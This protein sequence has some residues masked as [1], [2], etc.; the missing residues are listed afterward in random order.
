MPVKFRDYYEILGV[1]RDAS[2]EEIQKAYRKLARKYHPDVNTDKGAEDKF[3]EINEA[4]EV[5]KDPDKRKKYDA[6]GANWQSG[7]DFSPPPGWENMHF[8]YGPGGQ[9]MGDFNFSRFGHTGFSDFFDMLFGDSFEGLGSQGRRSAFSSQQDFGRGGRDH[10]VEL[11][12]TLEE[13]YHGGKKKFTLQS[14]ESD[15][16][17]RVRQKSKNY[18]VTIPAGITDG[19][20]I[21]LGGQGGKGAGGGKSGDLYIKLKILPHPVFR[22]KEYDIEV[23]VPVTPWEAALGGKIKVPTLDKTATMTLPPGT[24][25]GQKMRLK[26]KGLRKKGETRG[27]LY[28]VIKMAI[29]KKLTAKEKELF[30]KLAEVSSFNPRK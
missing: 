13:A 6:L 15:Q 7:Q 1:S 12:I 22:L 14:S 28:A 10:E 25:G 18:D 3:K 2:Q 8:K 20:K 19:G 4:H 21:R 16:M 26:G 24:Q 17:G 29:P 27:D 23:D 9:G 5:L 30:E 11:S